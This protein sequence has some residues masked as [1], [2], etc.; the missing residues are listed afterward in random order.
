MQYSVTCSYPHDELA[1]TQGLASEG[2][3]LLE[4]TGLYGR[5]SLRRVDIETG[6]IQQYIQLADDQFGEGVTVW[7]TLVFQLTW[8][9]GVVLIYEHDTLNLLRCLPSTGE[10]W[11]LT[12]NEKNL[13]ISDGTC[14]LRFVHPFTFRLE[15]TIEVSYRA[16]R[17]FRL[18]DVQYMDGLV[19]ANIWHSPA[20]AVIRPTDG[21]VIDWLDMRDL[22]ASTAPRNPEAVLNGITCAR[23]GRLLITGKFR[24]LL[25]EISL[26]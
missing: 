20:I 13:I 15:R 4:S 11:G 2:S 26:S 23:A 17:I 21:R 25:F 8:R 24:P 18:N 14:Y 19:F 5:S 1:F 7:E 22:V 10:G 3:S 6:Q 9:N 12:Q 16:H